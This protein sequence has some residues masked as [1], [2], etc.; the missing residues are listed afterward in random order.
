MRIFS[1]AALNLGLISCLG[2]AQQVSAA[3][4]DFTCISSSI[5]CSTG[6]SQFHVDVL[7]TS[8]NNE[9]LFNI[10]NTGAQQSAIEGVYFDDGTLLGIS[11]LIQQYDAGTKTGVKFTAGSATPGEL[12][13]ANNISPAFETTAGF[14]ADSDSPAPKYGINPGETLGILFN[15]KNASYFNDVISQLSSGDLRIGLHAQAFETGT[16]ASFVNAPLSHLPLPPAFIL[17]LSAL[18]GGL[19]FARTKQNSGKR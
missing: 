10:N 15:L 3:S 7:A 9:V 18:A 11:S 17:L 13:D 5:N 6:E 19:A 12:P 14:L 8:N 16:S 4:L 1:K 2:I